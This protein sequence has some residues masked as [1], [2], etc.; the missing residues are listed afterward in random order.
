MDKQ[1][2]KQVKDQVALVLFYTLQ[3]KSTSK[4]AR[5]WRGDLLD[6]NKSTSKSTSKPHLHLLVDLLTCG[7]VGK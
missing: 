4:S 7:Q 6:K 2:Q 3:N 5:K 1:V